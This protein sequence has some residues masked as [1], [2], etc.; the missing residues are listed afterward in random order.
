MDDKVIQRFCWPNTCCGSI[1]NHP[2]QSTHGKTQRLNQQS[3]QLQ[4]RGLTWQVF[5]FIVCSLFD[6]PFPRPWMWCRHH[7][8]N[9]GEVRL[10]SLELLF[11]QSS[12]HSWH[13]CKLRMHQSFHGLLQWCPQCVLRLWLFDTVWLFGCLACLK[14]LMMSLSCPQQTMK[15]SRLTFTP[16][17]RSFPWPMGTV[18]TVSPVSPVVVNGILAILA[19]CDILRPVDWRFC[20]AGKRCFKKIC[21]LWQVQT[22][23]S[24]SSPGEAV[25]KCVERGFDEFLWTLRFQMWTWEADSPANALTPSRQVPAIWCL[26]G[27]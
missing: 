20:G 1:L 15:A 19:F 4:S 21:H 18:G 5:C 14:S 6:L 7:T 16:P 10:G 13:K 3:S 26:R 22:P 17:P 12:V 8:W 11:E 24:A 25:W 27:S 23:P 9:V 2:C